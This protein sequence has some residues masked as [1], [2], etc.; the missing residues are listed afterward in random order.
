VTRTKSL[1]AALA[2][3]LVSGATLAYANAADPA[4]PRPLPVPVDAQDTFA[5]QDVLAYYAMYYDAKDADNYLAMFTPDATI[6]ADGQPFT[7]EQWDVI[8]KAK[9]AK[10]EATGQQRRH[11]MTNIIVT[12]TPDNLN[13]D[14]AT[15]TASWGVFGTDLNTGQVEA[16]NSGTY[17][18]TVVKVDGQW[19]ISQWTIHQ[20]TAGAAEPSEG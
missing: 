17:A 18:G 3:V 10:F 7:K 9:L 5:I 13:P 16:E 20:D 1:I 11:L 19:L 6:E 12:G 4:P 2:V 14:T 15:L 8:V